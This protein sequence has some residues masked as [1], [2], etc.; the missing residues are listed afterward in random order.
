MR[1]RTFKFPY[2]YIFACKFIMKIYKLPAYLF[3]IRLILRGLK[4]FF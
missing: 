4:S 1:N 2:E 3:F